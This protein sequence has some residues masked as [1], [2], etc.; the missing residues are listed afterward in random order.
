M[1]GWA[2]LGW[3][4]LGAA[5]GGTQR[6]VC[7]VS[8]AG[9]LDIKAGAACLCSVPPLR[10]PPLGLAPHPTVTPAPVL[11]PDP[12]PPPP[13][14]HKQA[15]TA[16]WTRP[17]ASPTWAA[18]SCA[19]TRPSSP[20]H[21]PYRSPSHPSTPL[22]SAPLPRRLAGPG[23][24]CLAGWPRWLALAAVSLLRAGGLCGC[25]VLL[26]RLGL[27]G[28]ACRVALGAAGPDFGPPARPGCRPR[29]RP[30][31]C[32]LPPVVGG[33]TVRYRWALGTTRW[34]RDVLDWQEW[35]GTNATQT[36]PV[37]AVAGQRLGACRSAARAALAPPPASR[38]RSRAGQRPHACRAGS[39]SPH[40]RVACW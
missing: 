3:A 37:R 17:P 21:P 35:A 33:G 7:C 18:A 6:G 8:T 16:A 4:G 10:L 26:R 27:A 39:I 29:R 22:V 2:G 13:H 5:G 24:P 23:W 14:T 19:P 31:R 15:A 12:T 28:I 34:G 20:T 40:Q 11:S 38:Q 36:V 25:G 32:A 30:E 1:G 9:R